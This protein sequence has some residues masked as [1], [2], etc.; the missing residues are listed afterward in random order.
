MALDSAKKAEIVAK[1]ARKDGDTGS[2]EVQVALLTTRISELTEHLKIF[3]K[4][5]SSRLGLLKMVGKRKR[6]LK[7]FKNKNYPAYS[8]LIAELNIRDK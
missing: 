6:L 8:K 2:T 4:D 5:H 3:K 1:F 7:Y